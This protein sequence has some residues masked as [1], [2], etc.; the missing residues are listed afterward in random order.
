MTLRRVCSVFV[1]IVGVIVL[2]VAGLLFWAMQTALPVA[3][4]TLSVSGIS[5]PITVM[6]D[7]IGVPHIFADSPQ[8]AVYGLG[9]VHAQDRGF[10]LE[11]TRRFASGR[12]AE[13]FGVAALEL[14]KRIRTLG[15]VQVAGAEFALLSAPDRTLLEAYAAGVNAAT[16]QGG[17]CPAFELRLLGV[18]PE[19]WTVLDSLLVHKASATTCSSRQAFEELL[20]AA[21][22]REV[23]KES[24]PDYFPS[25][26]E[27]WSSP[28]T[29]TPPSASERLSRLLPQ[30]LQRLEKQNLASAALV[31]LPVASRFLS[32]LRPHKTFLRSGSPGTGS[33]NWVVHGS[34][35]A[36]GAPLLAG[37][38]HIPFTIPGAYAAHLSAPNFEVIGA[39][40]VGIP[41]FIGGHNAH[42][43]WGIT[44][45]GADVVDL[46]VEEIQPGSPSSVPQFRTAHGWEP[47]TIRREEIHVRSQAKPVVHLARSSPHGPLISDVFPDWLQLA[48]LQQEDET[49][50]PSYALASAF[51]VLQPAAPRWGLNLIRAKNWL[52]FRE[53]LRNYSG[54]DVNFVY[55]D[56][57]GHIGYQ[58]AARI[59]LRDEL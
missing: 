50:S 59:P 58:L 46:F 7:S 8:D 52:D 34:R 16:E 55:A 42:I 48:G 15:L 19:P 12:L 47:L 53:A 25:Y 37:D 54:A 4:G 11:T 28:L 14:D 33:N 38:P 45:V 24:L 51:T 30:P 57:D 40:S 23:G 43:A 26:P 9:F 22:L 5:A 39:S 32:S 35:T 10:Q 36:T 18:Q 6:R 21:L 27:D 3:D 29:Q 31:K 20:T 1:G 41:F 44:C 2:G 17:T 56:V 49:Q 13:L